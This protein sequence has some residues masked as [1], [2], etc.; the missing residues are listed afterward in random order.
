MG[1]REESEVGGGVRGGVGGGTWQRGHCR[2]AERRFT[3]G[4]DEIRVCGLSWGQ[5]LSKWFTAL[6]S[7]LLQEQSMEVH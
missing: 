6:P 1:V 2:R 4:C 3:A 7:E 5:H